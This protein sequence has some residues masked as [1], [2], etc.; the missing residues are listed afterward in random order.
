M[1][2]N[3]GEVENNAEKDRRQIEDLLQEVSELRV[4]NRRLLE[5]KRSSG[6]IFGTIMKVCLIV[7]GLSVVAYFAILI[8]IKANPFFDYNSL[9]SWKF[10]AGLGMYSSPVLWVIAR[11]MKKK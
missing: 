8:Y 4:E 5:E 1:A 3:T 2:N 9:S 6:D 10:V 7:F 11:F